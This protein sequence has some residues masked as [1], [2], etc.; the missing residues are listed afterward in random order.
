MTKNPNAFFDLIINDVKSMS[1]EEVVNELA[2]MS[3]DANSSV[4]QISGFIENK[5]QLAR[6]NL[7]LDAREKLDSET[8]SI[9]KDKVLDKYLTGG[10]DIRAV[11][12]ELMAKNLLPE[13]FV[14]A[15]RE[16]DDIADNELE[17]LLVNMCK[18]GVL[19][20]N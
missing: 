3:I 8:S 2:D 4:E 17:D 15:F 16:G 11:F 12:I 19:D 7:L 1:D 6:K 13:D 5:T 20:G 10:K 18:I 14:V 9:D